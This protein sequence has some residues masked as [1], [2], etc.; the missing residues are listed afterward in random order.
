MKFAKHLLIYARSSCPLDDFS[1]VL[2]GF[3]VLLI[4]GCVLRRLVCC[5]GCIGLLIVGC[6]LHGL[7]RFVDIW[8]CVAWVLLFC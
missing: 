2:H 4:F 5:I 3:I 1:C 8:L 6:V 7:Y